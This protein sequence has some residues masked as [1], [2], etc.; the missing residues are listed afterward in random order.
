MIYTL[1]KRYE[2]GGGTMEKHYEV[3][4]YE[5]RTPMGVLVGG[6]TLKSAKDMKKINTYLRKTGL[7]V[8][9]MF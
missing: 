4:S 1:E 7:Q 8:E 3:C 2:F 6:K 9:K 5:R